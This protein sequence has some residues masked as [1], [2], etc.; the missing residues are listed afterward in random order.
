MK[1][2]LFLIVLMCW[3][4]TSWA[5]PMITG[6][7]GGAADEVGT[8]TNGKWCSSDGSVVNCTE[9][10]P[11]GSGDV[12]DV[13]D[14]ASG[15]CSAFSIGGIALGDTTP[16]A[17]GE[18][19]YATNAFL[20]FANSEDFKITAGANMWTLDSNTSAAF[21]ITPALTITGLTTLNGG[22]SAVG[23]NTVSNAAT[24]AGS[25]YFKE[26][27]DNGTNTVQLIGAAST[28]DVVITLPA[29]AGTV[30]LTGL[31]TLTPAPDD[32]A[33]SGTVATMQ[34]G[35]NLTIGQLC[36]RK[37]DGKW[38]KADADASTTMGALAMSTGTI[39][40][41]ATGV[42]LLQGFFRDDS[43]FDFTVGGMVYA[44]SGAT[45]AHTAGAT[46][47]AAPNG[48]G[49]QVQIVGYGYTADIIYFNPS[50]TI[51]EL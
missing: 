6:G 5:G 48:V 4:G 28:A 45:D 1:R 34:A 44:G 13:G 32:H 25:I 33:Y 46:N 27:S 20:F 14:C 26:D 24:S 23:T 36:Y 11:A 10:A 41:D 15:N 17:N 42:F 47:K 8:L 40:A 39:N 7:G 18:V 29:T 19:G 21:T 43:E 35:E 51:L 49:D 9:D 16:D 31:V 2:I 22:F 38:W 12:T 30:A 3:Y 50:T 37:S